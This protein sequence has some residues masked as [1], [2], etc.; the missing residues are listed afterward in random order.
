MVK[1]KIRMN[2]KIL[3]AK[4]AI[5]KIS[6]FAD[7]F[8]SYSV[9]NQWSKVIAVGER[10]IVPF[11]RGNTPRL[12]IVTD[13]SFEESNFK[14]K[15]IAAVLDSVPLISLEEISLAAFM[16]NHYFCSYFE[17]A[18]LMMPPGTKLNLSDIKY[19]IKDRNYLSTDENEKKLWECMLK[20]K[21]EKI[22]LKNIL[23]WKIKNYIQS[24][25]SL[26][27]AEAIEKIVEV[28]A[29]PGEKIIK[30]FK[31]GKNDLQS[32]TFTPKQSKVVKYL[33]SVKHATQKEIRYQT[34][35]SEYVINSLLKKGVIL[36]VKI[37]EEKDTSSLDEKKPDQIYIKP[38]LNDEQN[39]VFEKLLEVYNSGKFEISLLH[40]VTGS[41]KTEVL[42][43]LADKVIS[44]NKSVI[45]TVPEISLTAQFIDVFRKRYKDKT[46]LIHSGLS[47]RERFYAWKKLKQ[48]N[49]FV[50]L[51]TRSAIFAPVKNLGLVVID[52]EHEF[53]YKSDSNPR[54]N[55]KDIAK[56][57]CKNSNALLVFSSATPSIESYYKA[58]SGRYKLFTLKSRY[59]G[60]TL[61]DVKIIDM[62]DSNANTDGG[63]FSDELTNALKEN[64]KAGKQ[65]LI[66]VNR[67]GHSP[68][69]KCCDCSKVLLCPHCSVSL[70]YHRANNRFM[71]HYCGYSCAFSSK[72]PECG[73][74]KICCFGTGTQKAEDFLKK[75]LPEAKI[76][77]MDSDNKNLKNSCESEFKKFAD[78]EYDILLGTQMISK[79]FNFPN[80]T[81]VGVLS[82]DG[83]MYTGDYRSYEKTFSLLT[84]VVGRAGRGKYPGKAIIQ[85]FSPESELLNLAAKQDYETFFA[86]EISIRKAML[87]PPF[88]DICVIGFACESEK[89]VTLASSKLF[90][91]MKQ[92]AFNNYP[93]LPL[94]IFTPCPANIAKVAENYRYRIIVKC[95]N[96]VRFREMISK[97]LE[98]FSQ[99]SKLQ[100]VHVFVDINPDTIL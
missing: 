25:E 4:I 23:N 74:E 42:M 79:G 38:N 15:E 66:F 53:T 95:K 34:G 85:T 61:P 43:N 65:S 71:C 14:L 28:S 78:G 60:A 57:R 83:Y 50:V 58:K 30:I 86:H 47:D 88:V 11:G 18:K 20:S 97:T 55:A 80:V 7:E 73:S 84:Q 62:N 48:G 16:K 70:N 69:A 26:L 3:V 10:V 64:L 17:A 46:V 44:E 92:E 49:S 52:E 75:I 59:A 41:G 63:R 96:N 56:Y 99:E 8:Y 51:G 39:N 98:K 45:F 91:I 82:A 6:Y 29:F 24:L 94:R 12:G 2:N 90:K 31:I 87:Y 54:F 21:K 5:E 9:P 37:A 27:L 68:F 36:S 32:F 100:S 19:I 93:D 77:R 40:G 81:L 1:V 76:L 22:T 35:V 72:C 33:E 13:L 67:R 89:K